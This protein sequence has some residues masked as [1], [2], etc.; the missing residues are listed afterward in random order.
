MDRFNLL[1]SEDDKSGHSAPPKEAFPSGTKTKED[2]S[3]DW[4]EVLTGHEDVLF[5]CSGVEED[6]ELFLMENRII[7]RNKSRGSSFPV[8]GCS[9]S[10][11]KRD[12]S[13][14]LSVTS[15]SRGYGLV[16]ERS[17]FEEFW[18]IFLSN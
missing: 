6:R 12:G 1:N 14:W 7:V 15:S 3:I 5:A 8:D 10:F 9:V 17:D 13:F 2:E 18:R 4:K 11:R 16:L